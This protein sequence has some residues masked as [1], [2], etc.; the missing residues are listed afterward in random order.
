[1]R[2][3]PTYDDW[4]FISSLTSFLGYK[5]ENNIFLNR[6]VEDASGEYIFYKKKKESVCVRACVSIR[7]RGRDDLGAVR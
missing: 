2:E 1:M 4:E 3:N 6:C 5:Q 7:V